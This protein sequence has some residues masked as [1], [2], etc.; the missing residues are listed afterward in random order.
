MFQISQ[1]GNDVGAQKFL[2]ELETDTELKDVIDVTSSKLFYR[3][4]CFMCLKAN[5]TNSKQMQILNG[6]GPDKVVLPF[7]TQN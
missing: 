3:L 7:L 1:V 6:R 5:E 2:H 4:D